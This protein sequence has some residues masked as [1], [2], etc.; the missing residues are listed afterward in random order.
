MVESV[1]WFVVDIPTFPLFL[2]ILKVVLYQ[3]VCRIIQIKSRWRMN[4][5]RYMQI[6]KRT[7]VGTI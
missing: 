7:N 1:A 5:R 4:R 2:G 3:E 6:T